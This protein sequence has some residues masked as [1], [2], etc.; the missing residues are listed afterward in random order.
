MTIAAEGLLVLE[1]VGLATTGTPPATAA[2]VGVPVVGTPADTAGDVVRATIW[3]PR[4]GASAP[5][6]RAVDA[7]YRHGAESATVLLGVDGVLDGER[8]RA[9]FIAANRGV[10]AMTIAVGKRDAITA[11]L[12]EFG[13]LA[14]LVTIEGVERSSRIAGGSLHGEGTRVTLVTSEIARCGAHP[15]YLEFIHQL[16]RGSAAGATALRGVWGFHGDVAPHGDRVL[17]LRR[18]VPLI[19]ETIDTAERSAKWL[20]IAESLA[21]EDDLVYCGAVG[22]TLVPN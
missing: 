5:H 9:R 6:L 21:G 16:R 14:D 2:G 7:M 1:E 17:A 18:D 15:R 22:S 12:A 10:P 13:A 20:E 4:T 11:A 19:V 8:T 3:G